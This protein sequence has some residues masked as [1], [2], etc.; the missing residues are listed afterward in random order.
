[1]E[2]PWHK[3]VILSNRVI[4]QGL[5]RASRRHAVPDQAIYAGTPGSGWKTFSMTQS[6]TRPL[7]RPWPCGRW[8]P[9][10]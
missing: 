7:P 6:C 9:R 2:A 8:A 10:S 5:R 3:T 4:Y 1:M